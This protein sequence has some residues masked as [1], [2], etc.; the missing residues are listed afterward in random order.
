MNK[1][2]R[3]ARSKYNEISMLL[4]IKDNRLNELN[5]LVGNQQ[6]KLK[7]LTNEM[8]QSRIRTELEKSTSL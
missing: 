2:L 1:E 4:A 6:K 5:N 7:E 8:E 3:N